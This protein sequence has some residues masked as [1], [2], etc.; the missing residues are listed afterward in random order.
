MMPVRV[1]DQPDAPPAAEP[2]LA[3]V[4]V[5]RVTGTATVVEPDELAVEEPLEIRLG[6]DVDGRRVHAPVSVTMRTPGHDQELAIGFLF[7]EGI[8]ATPE[9]IAGS[10]GCRRANVVRI[11]LQ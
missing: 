4:R 9:Q 11:D 10:H 2:A 6:C 3:A 1:A 8:L 7:T 5:C